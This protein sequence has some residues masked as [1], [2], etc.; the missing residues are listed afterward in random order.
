LCEAPSGP[1]RQMGTV[2]FFLS[3]DSIAAGNCPMPK[4]LCYT[5]AAIALLL[6]LMFGMDMAVGMP[7]GGVS[8]TMDVAMIVAA[9]LLGYM[10]WATLR[11]RA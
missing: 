5:G 8:K 7:F 2:P 10:S 3:Q 1:F 9:V 6:L 11:E 4:A